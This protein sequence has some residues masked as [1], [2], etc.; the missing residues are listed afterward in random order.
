MDRERYFAL[1]EQ[2]LGGQLPDAAFGF[3]R[4]EEIPEKYIREL[5]KN[6]RVQGSFDWHEF[7]VFIDRIRRKKTPKSIDA[8][9]L[10][11][12]HRTINFLPAES[13]I[14]RM[15]LLDGREVNFHYTTIN[16]KGGGFVVPEHYDDKKEAIYSDVTPEIAKHKTTDYSWGYDMLGL[17]DG[18]VSWSLVRATNHMQASG[19]RCESIAAVYAIDGIKYEGEWTSIEKLRSRTDAEGHFVW[20]RAFKKEADEIWSTADSKEERNYLTNLAPYGRTIGEYHPV[21]VIRLQ[22]TPYRIKDFDKEPD[23]HIRRQILDHALNVVSWEQKFHD[24]SFPGL[25]AEKIDDIEKYLLLMAEWIGRNLGVLQR[26]GYFMRYFNSGNVTMAGELVDLDSL[27]SVFKKK[28][29]KRGEEYIFDGSGLAGYEGEEAQF[30][31]PKFIYK[32]IRDAV[33]ACYK[34][35][36]AIKEIL[37]A[38]GL[39]SLHRR[40]MGLKFVDSYASAL[41]DGEGMA[42]LVPAI[43]LVEVVRSLITTRFID[44][45]KLSRTPIDE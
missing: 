9:I 35:F 7:L 5:Y 16:S 13:L 27:F 14:E 19:A 29:T 6:P 28:K 22:R 36:T 17:M 4:Y 38:I 45:E 33:L 1:P 25:S 12:H 15:T 41:N 24:P 23:A 30:H 3:E 39:T 44:G 8:L 31:I 18:R 10:P 20:P 40:S 43:R 32:D 2:E 26:N 11:R 21:I 42:R 37:P 34:I